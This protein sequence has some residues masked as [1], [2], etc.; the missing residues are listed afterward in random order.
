MLN[1]VFCSGFSKNELKSPLRNFFSILCQ[2]FKETE[3]FLKLQPCL[4]WLISTLRWNV[5]LR[6]VVCVLVCVYVCVFGVGCCRKATLLD[7]TPLAGLKPL[8][9][10]WDKQ[11]L[12]PLIITFRFFRSVLLFNMF[13]FL[14]CFALMLTAGG[15][16]KKN[17]FFFNILQKKI[18]N[19]LALS[20]KEGTPLGFEFW[21][22]SSKNPVEIFVSKIN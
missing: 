16:E 1:L 10:G 15:V 17:I 8:K 11:T 19:K 6:A 4:H 9:T 13:F 7:K 21:S 14:F 2:S 22:E 12:Q 3:G 5:I 18:Q 20:H